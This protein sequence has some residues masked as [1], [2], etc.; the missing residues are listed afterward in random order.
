MVY[1]K[2]YS[3]LISRLLIFGLLCLSL[4]IVGTNAKF[5]H[6][7]ILM[8]VLSVGMILEL[9][10]YLNYTN[11]YLSNYFSSL[12]ES[13]SLINFNDSEKE[14][15]FR[16]LAHNMG[17]I[18]NL[19]TE[20]RLKNEEEKQFLE[21]L[22]K[23]VG[24]GI[25]AFNEDGKVRLNN[26]SAL[27]IFNFLHLSHWDQLGEIDSRIVTEISK[28]KNPQKAFIK[29]VI[30]EEMKELILFISVFKLRKETIRLIS[31]Q[32]INEEMNKK[33][34]NAWHQ[35]IQVMAHEIMSTISPIASLSK[36]LIKKLS[37]EGSVIEVSRIDQNLMEDVVESLEIIGK[38]G[39]GLI[40]FVEKYRSIAYL[41]EPQFEL[42]DL[43]DLVKNVSRLAEVEFKENIIIQKLGNFKKIRIDRS[44]TEQA[45]LNLV[46]N[47]AQATIDKENKEITLKTFEYAQGVCLEILDHGKGIP[48]EFMDKIFI[49]FFSAKEKGNGIGLSFARQ[50]IHLHGGEIIVTSTPEEWTRVKMFFPYAI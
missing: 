22:I 16:K 13:G 43:N 48:S 40:S 42:I 24:I 36:H 39:D 21:N 26:P 10:R 25:I 29:C 18:W 12:Y 15:S 31:I 38:R 17:E 5:I 6:T 19:L 34:V 35:V 44:L 27:R 33:E 28:S 3:G 20:A 32:D 4:G 23:H 45:L 47:S 50:V 37:P 1:K 11:R 41:P 8:L 2:F 49:P 14:E 9:L 30:G 46:R 7:F